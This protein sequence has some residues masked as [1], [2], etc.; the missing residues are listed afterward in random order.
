NIKS[1]AATGLAQDS[2]TSG[3]LGSLSMGA[4]TTSAP[5][6]TT[7]HTDPLSLNTAGALRIDGSGVTQPVSIAVDTPCYVKSGT[8]TV[9][10]TSNHA[11]CKSSSGTFK[12]LRAINTSA[13]L[14]YVRMYN[15]SSDPTC[16]SSTGFVESIPVP[17]SSTGAGIVDVLS[18][19]TYSTG[20][21]YCVTG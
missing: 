1:G 11:N 16:S 19:Y 3:Q 15:S 10:D 20:V 7:A 6:Y 18:V 12:G 5:T 2:T 9:N 8:G 13:T 4:V 21:S 14:A 17:A